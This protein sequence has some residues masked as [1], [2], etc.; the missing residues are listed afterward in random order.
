MEGLREA[1]WIVAHRFAVELDITPWEALL[2]AVRIAAGRVAY[3]EHKLAEAQD[4]RQLEPPNENEDREEARTG[5]VGTN[6]NW[7]VKQAEVWHDRLT[8]VSKM[9]IDAG[10]AERLVRQMELEAELMLRAT[11]KTFDELGLD[12]DT[13]QK[14]L[15]IMAKTLLALEAAGA[16]DVEFEDAKIDE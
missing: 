13:R 16:D 15:S 1:A 12:D 5:V 6:L 2:K 9:A 11:H 4:D 3:I 7:W 10:V 8:R 14:A